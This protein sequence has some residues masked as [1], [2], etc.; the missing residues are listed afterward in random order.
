MRSPRRL[1]GWRGIAASVALPVVLFAGLVG[2]SQVVSPARGDSLLPTLPSLTVLDLPHGG[3]VETYFA[4]GG[5]GVNQWHLIFS[6]SPSQ[7]ATVS[8]TVTA[9]VDGGTPQR[10]RQL[11]VAAGH[12]SEIVVLTPGDWRFRV[13]TPFGSPTVSFTVRTT[14]H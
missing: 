2:V 12:F 9:S 14:V 3:S 13:T 4:P 11:R 6:G 1:R 5:P 10:L 8:P 7:L